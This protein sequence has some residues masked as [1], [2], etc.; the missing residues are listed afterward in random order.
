MSG[1]NSPADA[2]ARSLAA[3]FFDRVSTSPDKE[4]FRFLHDGQWVS[5]TWRDAATRVESLAAGLLA[6]GVQPE[7]RV[8]IASSTRYEW[9]LADLAVM[10]AGAAT[11]TVYANTVGVEI[12]GDAH[13][14]AP[15]QVAGRDHQRP[16]VLHGLFAGAQVAERAHPARATTENPLGLLQRGRLIARRATGKA[17]AQ[18]LQEDVSFLYPGAQLHEFFRWLMPAAGI[19]PTAALSDHGR[20]VLLQ[21]DDLGTQHLVEEHRLGHFSRPAWTH[22][23]LQTRGGGL[24][25]RHDVRVIARRTALSW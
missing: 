14:P 19:T 10:C 1:S 18:C 21:S 12:P 23:G 11:T 20:R 17:M 22:C 13:E 25:R 3:L 5:A 15:G 6:L 7:Q 9:I 24:R 8:G 16:R 2:R 4:A